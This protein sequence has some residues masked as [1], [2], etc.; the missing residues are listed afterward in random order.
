[1]GVGRQHAADLLYSNRLPFEHNDMIFAVICCRWGLL[2]GLVTWGLFVM[3]GLGAFLAAGQCKDPFAR[4]VAVGVAA[5]LMAQMLINTGM[6]TGLLPITGMTLPFVSA[7]GSSMV[8]A[9]I[10]I[11][12]LMMGPGTVA[13]GGGRGDGDARP[14][15]LPRSVSVVS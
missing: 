9:W 6:T 13:G 11:G 5:S 7:G 12:L 4:L 2:G 10:M 8:A 1:M 15:V 3:L 14:R